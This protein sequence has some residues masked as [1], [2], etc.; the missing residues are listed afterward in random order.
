[1]Q[2]KK[3][4]I[5]AKKRN[6][7][8]K[9][10]YKKYSLKKYQIKIKPRKKQFLILNVNISDM[11]D[12]GPHYPKSGVCIVVIILVYVVK[13]KMII[14]AQVVL[15]PSEWLLQWL[16]SQATETKTN[17]SCMMIDHHDHIYW[18][19]FKKI[20]YWFIKLNLKEKI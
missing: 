17:W 18:M 15:C 6:F 3:K 13:T 4:K 10:K 7:N 11:E 9:I 19:I 12:E 8:I 20:K 2:F 1:M 16:L 5:N 14:W